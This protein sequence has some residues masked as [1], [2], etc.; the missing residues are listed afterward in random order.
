MSSQRAFDILAPSYDDSFTDTPIARYLRQ[1]VRKRLDLHFREG[2]HVLEL[3]CG[4]GEDA[5][6]LAEK[7]V[8]VTATDASEGM[9]AVARAKT[10]GNPLVS[11]E[12]LDLRQTGVSNQQLSFSGQFDGAFSNFGPLNCLNDWLPLAKALARRVKPGGVVA[13]AVMSPLC[14]WELGWHGVHLDFKTATRRWRRNTTFQPEANAEAMPICYPTIR[15]LSSDFAL[16]FRRI[17]LESIGLFLPPSDV[18]GVVE[19][20]PR[21]MKLLMKLEEQFAQVSQLALFADHYWIEF[22]RLD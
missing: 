3:G 9:L 13:L 11:V 8:R 2:D 6:Y 16:R 21:L 17:H 19:K 12:R 20:R 22:E 4:T 14:L 18:F 5:L 10:A 1:Q 15:R 7:G